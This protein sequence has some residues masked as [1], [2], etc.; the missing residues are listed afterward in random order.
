M[1]RKFSH[2]DYDILVDQTVINLK[3]LS[4]LKGGEYAGDEDR[5]ANFRRN[6]ERLGL[7]METIWAVYAAKH[8]DAI[9]Q[10][11]SDMQHGKSRERMESLANRLDDLIVYALLFKAML[12]DRER[13]DGETAAARHGYDLKMP[14]VG[15][16]PP[17]PTPFDTLSKAPKD[18]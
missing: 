8:W 18:F 11:V 16:T 17:W 15:T 2:A 3:K 6:G 4:S 7:P 5:L 14:Q 9:M 12:I 1:S 13:P 10:Y